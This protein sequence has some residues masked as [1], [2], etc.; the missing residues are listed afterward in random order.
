MAAVQEKA[1]VEAVRD[2]GWGASVV[3]VLRS[4]GKI[5]VV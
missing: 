2:S 5:K 1:G 3:W 4:Y